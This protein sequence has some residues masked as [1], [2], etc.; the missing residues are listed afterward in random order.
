MGA[1]ATGADWRVAS[2]PSAERK[3]GPGDRNLFHASFL[4]PNF[5]EVAVLWLNRVKVA[6][7]FVKSLQQ[8]NLLPRGIPPRQ[9]E[10]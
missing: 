3:W 1:I 10:R 4:L 5:A 6:L 8:A 7:A 9:L 2:Q